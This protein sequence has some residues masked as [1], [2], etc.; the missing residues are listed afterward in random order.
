[1]KE[2]LKFMPN[3][4]LIGMYPKRKF[5]SDIVQKPIRTFLI[6][7]STYALNSRVKIEY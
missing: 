4:C 6:V 3:V 2:T 7:P 5:S 1:M